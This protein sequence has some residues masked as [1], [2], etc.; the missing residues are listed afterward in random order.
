MVVVFG[1]DREDEEVGIGWDVPNSSD[2]HPPDFYYITKY[3][4]CQVK[5]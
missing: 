2:N 3:K 4:K 1:I 5:K